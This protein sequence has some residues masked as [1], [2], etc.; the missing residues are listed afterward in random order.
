MHLA[1]LVIGPGGL[2]QFGRLPVEHGGE[3]FDDRAPASIVHFG[4]HDET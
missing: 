4:G 1:A 3:A 2:V